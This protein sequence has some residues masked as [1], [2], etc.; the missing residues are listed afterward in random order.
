MT[1]PKP[2][3]GTDP[4]LVKGM[5]VQEAGALNH[6]WRQVRLVEEAKVMRL[7]ISNA[8][9]YVTPKGARVL[10]GQLCEMAARIERRNG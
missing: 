6:I 7:Q 5:V 2:L 1:K 3:D 10:A 8:D 9:V 4:Y